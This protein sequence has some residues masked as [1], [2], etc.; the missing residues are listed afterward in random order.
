MIENLGSKRTDYKPKS[1]P[2]YRQEKMIIRVGI[3]VSN[4]QEPTKKTGSDIA[5]T[6]SGIHMSGSGT[7]GV[8]SSGA[9]NNVQLF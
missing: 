8:A 4:I 9:D 2:T 1:A 5:E 3:E 7:T 6:A